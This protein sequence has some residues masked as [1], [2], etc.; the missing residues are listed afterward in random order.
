MSEKQAAEELGYTTALLPEPNDE[1][2]GRPPKPFVKWAGGKRRVIPHLIARMPETFG[3]FH[4]PFIGGGA[5][6]FFLAPTRDTEVPWAHISDQNARLIRTYRAIRDDVDGVIAV[7]ETHAKQHDRNYY[8]AT[9]SWDI[10]AA[11][12]DAEVA[13]WVVYL[14]R[15]CFNG[16]YRVNRKGG[17]NVP[18]GNYKAPKILNEDNLRACSWA[19]RNVG[20]EREDFSAVLDRANE[21]DVVYFDPPYA[22]VSPTASF[23]S[24]TKDGFG[25]DDQT[26]LRDL[27][28]ELKNKGV[29]VMLSNHDVPLIRELYQDDFTIETV[30]VA[31]AINSRAN[32]RGAVPEVIVS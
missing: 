22:P 17:F 9:R 25:T 23:T 4:E 28:L 2:E 6:L 3:A 27:A 14:N 20:I 12:K 24:Y 26:R 8:Y 10:D 18:M 5:L 21:G 32:G 30:L 1:P 13:A 11:T 7:L 29:S 16:L 15:T 19:L 31:R